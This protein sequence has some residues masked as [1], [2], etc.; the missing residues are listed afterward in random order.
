METIKRAFACEVKEIDEQERSIWFVAS[1][2]DK[3]RVG[4][5]IRVAGWKFDAYDRNPVF[6]WAHDSDELPI[7][8]CVARQIDGARLLMK[9]QFATVEENPLADQVYRL[10]KGGYLNAVSV[11]FKPLKRMPIH[12]EDRWGD[13]GWEFIE[14]ELLE[15]SAVPVPANS[16]A[17][18]LMMK[19]LDSKEFAENLSKMTTRTPYSD[20][21]LSAALGRLKENLNEMVL[22]HGEPLNLSD[23]ERAALPPLGGDEAFEVGYSQEDGSEFRCVGLTIEMPVYSALKAYGENPSD[24]LSNLESLKDLTDHLQGVVEEKRLGKGRRAELGDI[25]DKMEREYKA[26]AGACDDL[27]EK[28]KERL[29]KMLDDMTPDE[30]DEP[31]AL[32][33]MDIIAALPSPDPKEFDLE[34]IIAVLRKDLAR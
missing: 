5:I 27:V 34:A 1:T 33:V 32:D 26:L 15:L 19:G 3:D 22:L 13:L 14:Q 10:Y 28:C 9:I 25:A 16:S 6:L 30:D 21:I 29:R 7:G 18:Q 2:E 20:K 23:E 11:G 31:K 12:P 24:W 4:D 17:L 8:K